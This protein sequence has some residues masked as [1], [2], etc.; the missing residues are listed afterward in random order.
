MKR[1]WL[2]GLLLGLSMALLLGGGVAVAQDVRPSNG[3]N[4]GTMPAVPAGSYHTDIDNEDNA[5]SGNPDHDMGVGA[6]VNQCVWE[7]DSVHPIEFRISSPGGQ[8]KLTIAAWDIDEDTREPGIPEEDGVYFN[9]AFLG[10]LVTG[11]TETWTVST[12]S[13]LA[14]GNDL[15]EAARVAPEEGGCFGI[16]WG[17]LDIAEEEFVPEPG[18]VLLLGSGLMGLAGYAALRLRSG[19]AL[20]WRTRE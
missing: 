18:S 17:A 11:P 12:F 2:R 1:H 10:N 8:A 7:Q 4:V 15:V 3:W 16:A 5:H 20:R 19:Q 9:G 13:V 6:G 14:T